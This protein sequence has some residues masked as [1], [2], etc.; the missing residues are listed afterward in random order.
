[1]TKTRY[2][3]IKFHDCDFTSNMIIVL[4][5]LYADLFD[6]LRTLPVAQSPT[7]GI[8]VKIAEALEELSGK[9]DLRDFIVRLIAL[10]VLEFGLQRTI[11]EGIRDVF[12]NE[13][14]VR[15]QSDFAVEYKHYEDYFSKIKVIFHQDKSDFM[16][17]WNNHEDVYLDF[18]TGLVATK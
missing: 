16:K 8:G 13:N 14:L 10:Q 1:M 3:E 17:E 18:Y 4:E 5:R 9:V 7:Y 11:L 6:E 12:I 15:S 2:L